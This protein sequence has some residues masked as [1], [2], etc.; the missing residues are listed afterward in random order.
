MRHDAFG[1]TAF[2]VPFASTGNR[3]ELAVVGARGAALTATL[4]EA[5]AWLRLGAPLVR[6]DGTVAVTFDVVRSA[7]VN[8]P[9]GL[10]LRLA[11]ADGQTVT[12]AVRVVV[13]PPSDLVLDAPRPN[14]SAGRAEIGYALPSGERVRLAVY[15]VLGREVLRLRDGAEEAAGFHRAEVSGLAAGLYVVRLVAGGAVR[16]ARLVRR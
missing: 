14:P 10:T 4:Q 5:P 3:L 8:A 15:D 12:H 2:A 9:G 6:D 7:P 11:S 13:A 16:T 1:S